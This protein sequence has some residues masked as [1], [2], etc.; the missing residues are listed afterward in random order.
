MYHGPRAWIK[1]TFSDPPHA[2]G[3]KRSPKVSLRGDKGFQVYLNST[4]E[5]GNI[6]GWLNDGKIGSKYL[7]INQSE[8]LVIFNL[9]SRVLTIAQGR[10][11]EYPNTFKKF[12]NCTHF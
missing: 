7:E 4:N 5:Q 6:V 10:Q 11:L 2:Q 8:W 3:H 12:P 9:L 1:V